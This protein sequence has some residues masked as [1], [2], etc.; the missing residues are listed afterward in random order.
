[1]P[2]PAP[3]IWWSLREAERALFRKTEGLPVLLV[4]QDGENILEVRIADMV[5]VPL[6]SLLEQGFESLRISEQ[7]QFRI[8]ALFEEGARLG[9]N[10]RFHAVFKTLESDFQGRRIT[11]G[12][13]Y[14]T[15][16]LI[17]IFGPPLFG[18]PKISLKDCELIGLPTWDRRDP[19]YTG[20]RPSR[21]TRKWVI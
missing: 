7:I 16:D 6:F 20:P 11:I 17:P 4:G 9:P 10:G 8:D 1:M 3:I 15:E 2:I 12:L 13:S 5:D 14:C 18:G 21:Y 19:P